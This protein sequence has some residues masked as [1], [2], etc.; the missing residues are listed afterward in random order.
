VTQQPTN[1]DP[2]PDQ[3]DEVWDKI[4]AE[5]EPETVTVSKEELDELGEFL[6]GMRQVFLAHEK[7][8][9]E[10]ENFLAEVVANAV[11]TDEGEGT[12]QSASDGEQN[13]TIVDGSGNPIDTGGNS[14]PGESS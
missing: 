8:I 2:L 13:T 11:G 6:G 7:R 4:E 10:I 5:E 12:D 9:T 3:G 14:V 1:P